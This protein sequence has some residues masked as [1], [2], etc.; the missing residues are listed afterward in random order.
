MWMMRCFALAALLS[1]CASS[2]STGPGPRCASDGECRLFSDYC[3]GCACR[4]LAAGEAEPT[5]SGKI[6]QCL[7]DP[8]QGKRAVCAAGACT[9]AP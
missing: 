8:C 3:A 9:L 4:A 5:C 6:V 1:A 2:G 7:V